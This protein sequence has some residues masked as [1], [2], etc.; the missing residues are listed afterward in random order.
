MPAKELVSLNGLT[1][2]L[3]SWKVSGFPDGLV[4]RVSGFS[5]LGL[6]MIDPPNTRNPHKLGASS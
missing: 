1:Q 4:Y 3:I 6:P 5:G 2:I